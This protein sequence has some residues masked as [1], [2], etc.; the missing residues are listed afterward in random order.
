MDEQQELGQALN[1]LV[2]AL[3][4]AGIERSP[5][6]QHRR[7]P[8]LWM[9]GCRGMATRPR[10]MPLRM[11]SLRQNMQVGAPQEQSAGR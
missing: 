1:R 8:R 11:A 6:L 4:Q 3:P 7:M 10:P 2:A 9:A 5:A